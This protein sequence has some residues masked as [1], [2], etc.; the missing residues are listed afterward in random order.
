ML[1][2]KYLKFSTDKN[3]NEAT[4]KF[5]GQLARSQRWFDLEFYWIEVNFSTRD[6]DLYKK[7]FQRHEDTQDK[8]TYKRFKFQ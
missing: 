3:K 8:N 1:C 2:Q 7:R 5:Q 6:P 4:F